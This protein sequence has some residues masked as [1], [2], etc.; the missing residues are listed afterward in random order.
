MRAGDR[1]ADT[2]ARD[3]LERIVHG[4]IPVGSLLPK[5]D[6]LAASY[7]SAR[8]VVR[9]AIKLLE[10]H[11]LVKPTRRLGTVALDPSAS[12]S[13][14]VVRALLL[15][16]GRIDLEVFAG[17]LEIRAVLDASM[18]AA[19]AARRTAKDLEALD[20]VLGDLAASADDPPSFHAAIVTLSLT[21]AR[22]AHNPLYLVLA[23]WH[24][25]AVMDLEP[26]FLTIRTAGRPHVEGIALLVECVRRKDAAAAREL[27]VAFHGWATP[28]L[29]ATARLVN[30]E[31]PDRPRKRTKA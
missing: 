4:E 1:K 19:A 9:E 24:A 28:R 22:A 16:A 10:V 11:R 15:H 21:L 30:G 17:W 23:Q 8:S 5:E 26:V 6:E 18:C 7:G 27:V 31:H 13:S 20:R 25:S 14:D 29:L 12:P 3:L 2:I